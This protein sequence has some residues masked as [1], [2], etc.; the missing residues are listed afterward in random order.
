MSHVINPNA[1]RVGKSHLW[2][3][4]DFI[5]L[6]S[7][8]I[9]L[10]KN[11][12]LSHG[13]EGTADSILNRNNCILVKSATIFNHSSIKLKLLYYPIFKP[14]LRDIFSPR[15]LYYRHLLNI[16][17]SYNNNFKNL[18]K[19]LWLLKKNEYSMRFMR[20]KKRINFNKWITKNMFKG[21][22]IWSKYLNKN[23]RIFN[24][25]SW[26][27]NFLLKNNK[28]KSRN[29]KLWSISRLKHIF[30]INDRLLSKQISKRL[31]IHIQVTS[32][33]IFSYMFKKSKKNFN[34]KNHQSH[35]WYEYH[36]SKWYIYSFYDL[37][38]C[39]MLL[40]KIKYGENLLSKII[41][42]S[43]IRMSKRKIQPKQLFYF[44]DKVLKTLPN[45]KNNFES[46]R[47]L[48]TGKLRGGTSRTK[49]FNI[50]FGFIPRQSID[51]N[52]NYAFE[53]IHSKYG[54]YGIKIL[55]WRK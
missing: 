26:R 7:N 45:L 8:N 30:F 24:K 16:P 5:N 28:Y 43:L 23:Y 20:N 18:I 15:Y 31:G 32:K 22:F 41:K 17:R 50:G 55:T 37:V 2:N 52:I 3:H 40:S 13:I 25:N 12:N 39:I 48:I 53:N 35:I 47:I 54:S 14:I 11:I 19:K 10:Y 42:Y 1:F 49:V 36:R 9:N 46:V 27:K 34:I 38:N 29:W 51:K 6:N 21:S 33:N 44:L 4:N